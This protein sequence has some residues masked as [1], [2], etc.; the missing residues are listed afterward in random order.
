[1]EELR[2]LVI[3]LRGVNAELRA[4][5]AEQAAR[6][7]ELERRLNADSSTSSNP[8]SSD[9]PYRKPAR[10]S[11]REASGRKPGKQLGAP[12]ATMELVDNPNGTLRC[13][14]RCC[15][16][17]GTDLSEAPITGVTRRQVTD[18]PQPPPPW[19]RE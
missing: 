17:C 2:A 12:G 11:A 13:D 18:L 15:G 1:V 5:N 4:R 8:P 16:Q 10:R 7:V 19:V 9:S 6:I 3:E 14:P